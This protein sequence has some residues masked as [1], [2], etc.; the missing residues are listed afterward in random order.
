MT[1]S[2]CRKTFKKLRSLQAHRRKAHLAPRQRKRA[3][4]DRESE[5]VG[6][7][8]TPALAIEVM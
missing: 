7:Q 5:P 8:P 4:W 1:C 6:P 3:Q 2:K